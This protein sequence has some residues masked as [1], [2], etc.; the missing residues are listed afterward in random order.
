MEPQKTEDPVG[1]YTADNITVLEGLEAVRKRPAM[2]IGSTGPAGLHHL[3]YEVVDNSIDEALA[4]HCDTITVTLHDD[5]SCSVED[6][7]RGIPVGP[8]SKYPDKSAAEIVLTVL[9]AGGKF[10]KGTYK[11]SGGLHGVG[12]SCVNALSE[13]LT[14]D[15][16]RN[17]KH[18]TQRFNRGGA[19]S[20]LVEGKDTDKRGT[21]VRFMPDDLI[22]TETTIFT[23]EILTRRLRELAFLNPGVSIILADERENVSETFKYEGGIKSFVEFLNKARTSLHNE[24]AF[25]QG[26]KDDVMV[27]IALQWTSS[28][29]STISSFVN[30]INTIDGGTHVSGLKAGLTRT[31]NNHALSSGLLKAS[32][33]ESIGGDDIREGLTCVVSV[34]VPEPQFEG[35]TK[36]KLGNSE[37]KGIVESIVN[38]QLAA[39]LSENPRVAR[40]VIGKAVEASRAREAARR[41]RDLARRKS[42]LEGGDLPGKLADCQEKDPSKCELYLVEG[43]SAGGSAKQGRD[44]RYQAILPLRGKI[45]NVEKAR[46]DR[47]LANEEIR[48]IISALGAGI[49]PDFDPDKLRYSR[50]IIMTDADVDGSHIRTLLLTFFF[51][52]MPHLVKG[53]HL[54]IAQPPLYKVKRGK[55]ERYLKDDP[56]LE[57]FLLAQGIRSLVL[58]DANGNVLDSETLLTV[59]D[60]VRRYTRRLNEGARRRVPVVMDAW[61]TLGGHRLDFSSADALSGIVPD[62]ERVLGVLSPNLHITGTAVKPYTAEDGTVSYRLSVTTLRDGTERQTVLGPLPAEADAFSRLLDTLSEKLPLPAQISGVSE[63]ISGWRQLLETVLTN[64]RKGFEIQRYKGLGEMNPDQLW[65]T[66]MDPERRTLLQVKVENDTEADQIFSILMGDS[67]DPRRNFI[68]TNALNVRNL[69]V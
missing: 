35:Q 38:D 60:G 7:G 22:F 44:R 62:L 32:K 46:F 31:V 49:G 42:A 14:L 19:V 47:M 29:S 55:K 37:V 1:E 11:V 17:G 48:T 39:F 6:N 15:V 27:D 5:E 8:H 9:H 53:G 34:K 57:E 58:T 24:V 68:Q 56:A 25:L 20:R 36:G 4:G 33:N 65:E 63:P 45:L 12:V 10:N 43:D 54:Y 23:R 13:W 50:L 41:A 30:N 52:Q 40:S 2:Y 26:E 64:A 59:V 3:V 28:Y 21:R 61:H 66:T 16:W 67:V 69:D 51:R 18:H